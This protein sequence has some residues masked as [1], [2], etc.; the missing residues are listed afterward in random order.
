[1]LHNRS[2]LV[3]CPGKGL[4]LGVT[5]TESGLEEVIEAMACYIIARVV[6]RTMPWSL[7]GL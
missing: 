6:V 7:K 4:N 5:M 1:M 2:L 3:R